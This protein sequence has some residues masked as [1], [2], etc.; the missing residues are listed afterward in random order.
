MDYPYSIDVDG[1]TY[2]ARLLWNSTDST[3]SGTVYRSGKTAA[4]STSEASELAALMY[5]IGFYVP[6]ESAAEADPENVVPMSACMA[7]TTEVNVRSAPNTSGTIEKTLA[8]DDPVAVVGKLD[9]WYQVLFGG[10]VAYMSA[11][12]LRAA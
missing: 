8:K 12:Y 7:T 11:D 4:L 6:D 10:H 3:W 5:Q 9:G 1:E 2:N